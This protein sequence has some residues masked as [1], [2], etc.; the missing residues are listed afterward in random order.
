M[1]RRRFKKNKKISVL[2]PNS[3]S[4]KNSNEL[5]ISTKMASQNPAEEENSKRHWSLEDFEIGKPLG[6]GKFGIVYVA[7]E[8]KVR[9]LILTLFLSPTFFL[10]RFI[11]KLE[12]LTVH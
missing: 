10:L 4:E 12:C 1:K 2:Y 5:R 8:V 9:F 7:R 11:Q 3:N 6:R